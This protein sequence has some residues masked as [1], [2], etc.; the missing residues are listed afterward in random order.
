LL[1][2]LNLIFPRNIPL[3]LFV[4]LAGRLVAQEN[5]LSLYIYIYIYMTRYSCV[6]DHHITLLSFSS[7]IFTASQVPFIHFFFL[8]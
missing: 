3:L 4:I 2:Q 6:I 5:A 7:S 8:N 1:F